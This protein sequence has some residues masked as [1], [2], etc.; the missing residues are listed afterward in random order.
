MLHDIDEKAKEVLV[1]S[2]ADDTRVSK[3]IKD[4]KDRKIMEEALDKLY[5]WCDV[6]KMEFNA[7]KFE[8]MVF[9]KKNGNQEKYKG[10]TGEDIETKEVVKDLGVVVNSSANFKD[11][12]KNTVTACKVMSGFIFRTF[13]TRKAE[14]LLKLYKAYIRS[15][16]EYCNVVWCPTSQTEIAQIESIQR[17][18]TFKIEEVK[19][20]DYWQRLNI[21]N[22]Y[23]LERRRDF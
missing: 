9:G 22:L 5:K 18:F 4:P 13:T 8:H 1:R 2:F 7:D 21:L 16:T 15:K 11:Q 14:P 23:S 6:N 3:V 20:L 12:I 19:E 10:P 17:S